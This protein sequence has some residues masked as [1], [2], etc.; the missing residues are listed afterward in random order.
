M[1]G[2]R[3]PAAMRHAA[4]IPIPALLMFRFASLFIACFLALFISACSSSKG[5]WQLDNVEGHLPNLEFQLTSDSGKPA[6]AADFKG[7]IDLLYFGYT[8]CPDVCP[9]TLTHL[10]VV[11][12]RLGA[13]ADRVHVLFVS[14]DPARDTPEALHAYVNAFDSRVTGLTG[15]PAQIEALAKRYRAAFN[16]EPANPHGSYDVS[17]SSG[18]YVFDRNGH[19]R[20]LATSARFGRRTSCTIC[21]C[22]GEIHEGRIVALVA[23]DCDRPPHIGCR[24]WPRQSQPEVTNAWVRW[25]PGDLPAGRLRHCGKLPA[26]TPR[27]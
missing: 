20:L 19:A 7:K 13:E 1:L 25:L 23:S 18:I 14:V 2:P 17:H 11:L 21:A 8:H 22:F 15:T 9:L 26:T 6:S 5:R 4:S 27:D 12:Q 24:R 3:L 16:S 10:H